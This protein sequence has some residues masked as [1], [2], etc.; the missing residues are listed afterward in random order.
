M[1]DPWTNDFAALD[2]R[3]RKQLRSLA[4][5]RAH[6]LSQPE[7][8]RMRFFKNRPL[9]AALVVVGL[10]GAASGAVYAVDRVFL[11]VDPDET[12][13][14]IEQDVQHQLDQAGIVGTVHAEKSDGR[15]TVAIQ[16]TDDHLGSDL[17]VMV[18]RGSNA[19]APQQNG[20]RVQLHTDLSIAQ[21]QQLTEAL[22]EQAFVEQLMRDDMA[23]HPDGADA[24]KTQLASHGFHDVTVEA[25]DHAITISVN[26]P[27][28]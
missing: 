9:L 14:E 15:L 5:V 23:G 8:S 18:M 12:A 21:Q 17:P 20:V 25:A 19:G 6:V 1:A 28:N 16:S 3:S 24:Y 11:S 26:A 4:A 22:G 27:P 10:V 2:E 7:N 13:P